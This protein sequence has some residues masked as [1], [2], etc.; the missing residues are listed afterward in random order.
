VDT[1]GRGVSA[2]IV[3]TI[4]IAQRHMRY[5]LRQPWSS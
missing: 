5:L 4:S 2:A 1:T 3:Q